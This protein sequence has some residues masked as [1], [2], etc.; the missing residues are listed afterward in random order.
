[1]NQCTLASRYFSQRYISNSGNSVF[2]P[3]FVSA[4]KNS[5]CRDR[6]FLC[7]FGAELQDFTRLETSL[8]K[9]GDRPASSLSLQIQKL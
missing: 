6:F 3:A 8:P 5:T 7:G 4:D 1:M 9:K 2:N